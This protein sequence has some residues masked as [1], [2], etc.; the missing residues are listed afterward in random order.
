[1]YTNVNPIV[2][3]AYGDIELARAIKDTWPTTVHLLCRF[4]ISHNIT[5]ALTGS[6][7]ASLRKFTN[8]FW[9]VGSIEDV[10]NLRW[11]FQH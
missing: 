3:F 9:R 4:H 2:V 11:N 10:A 6:L 7:R 1:M 8:D 5:R